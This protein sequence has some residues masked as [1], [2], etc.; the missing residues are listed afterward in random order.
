M[1]A[2]YR[3]QLASLVFSQR[4]LPPVLVF[5][6]A[7]SVG[8]SSGAGPLLG[9]YAFCVIA[10]LGCAT[11]LTI[12]VVNHE[13]PTQRQV[14]TVTVG[15][16]ERVLAANV[17]TALTG[18]SFMIVIG[19]GYPILMGHYIVTAT[20]VA[21][22]ALAQ[23]AMALL[24]MAL[25]LLTSRLVIP[26]LGVAVIVAVVVLLAMLLLPWLSPV[27][28]LIQLLSDA[29]YP[30]DVAVRAAVLTCVSAVILAACSI[31]THLVARRGD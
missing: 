22:G 10:V 26:R 3:Y 6:V 14:V 5:L 23:L 13:D 17:A 15:T 20:A 7:L 19:L 25:G 29:P 8:T 16:A 12:A 28:P 9:A 30:D 11:W 4:Y 27:R 18:C 1:I 21:T 31:A 24:G 2:L